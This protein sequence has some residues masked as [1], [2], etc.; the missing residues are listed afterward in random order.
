MTLGPGCVGNAITFSSVDNNQ[1][2]SSNNIVSSTC[3]SS[4]LNILNSSNLV[5]NCSQHNVSFTISYNYPAHS[6]TDYNS[7][8]TIYF[9]N[10]DEVWNY[11]HNTNLVGSSVETLQSISSVVV[12]YN[13]PIDD[14]PVTQNQLD[15]LN[16][17]DFELYSTG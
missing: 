13:G 12:S 9:Q 11:L 16:G 5:C 7:I 15:Y 1:L 8:N 6:I 3:N 4:C 14:Y 17:R 10:D 2:N